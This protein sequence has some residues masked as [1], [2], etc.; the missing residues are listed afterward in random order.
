MPEPKKTNKKTRKD[1]KKKRKF[2]G[3]QHTGILDGGNAQIDQSTKK[4]DMD[5]RKRKASS[6]TSP[7]ASLSKLGPPKKKVN[8]TTADTSAIE[9]NRIIDISLLVAFLEGFKCPECAEY[10]LSVDETMFG[11]ASKISI[12]CQNSDCDYTSSFETSRK[13]PAQGKGKCFAINRQFP[14]AMCA[15]G[16]HYS[17]LIRL[18]ANLDMP[19]PLSESSW[20]QHVQ[21]IA[22]FTKTVAQCSMKR[23]ANAVHK[24]GET[25]SDIT[26]SCDNTWQ[27]RGFS[28]KNGISTV[29]TVCGSTG[30]SR[31]LDVEVLSNFC[32]LCGIK[33]AK[34]SKEDFQKWLPSHQPNCSKNHDGTAGAMEPAGMVK[35]FKRSVDTRKLCYTGYLGDGD[36]KSYD[37]VATLNP[38]LYGKKKI[39]KLECCGHIQKRMGKRLMDKVTASKNVLYTDDKTGKKYKGLGGIGRLTQKTIQRIQGHYGAA[40]REN[41]GSVS[42]M[43]KAIWRIWKHYSDDHKDCKDWCPVKSGKG[44]SKNI[45]PKF[46]CTLIKPVFEALS[47]DELLQ[48]CM[49]G[50]SQNT[51]E[52]FHNLIWLRCPKTGF[53]GRTRLELAVNDATIVYNEGEVSRMTI[54]RALHL[55]ASSHLQKGLQNIDAKRLK[56]AY[57]PGLKSVIKSRRARSLAAKGQKTDAS[58][59]AGSF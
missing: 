52:S 19:S 8:T 23:A 53:V 35:I 49:H 18:A 3:N 16:R 25:I 12:V 24:D 45:L 33:R 39:E 34:L 46:V 47:S 9:G 4:D 50:G 36:S 15:I 41:H 38:P 56:N 17:H 48:K 43:K 22:D 5:K 54:F 32:S 44:Q 51:N 6:M 28:S 30:A 2:H 1:R 13:I 57:I 26:V 14:L 42:E 37:T 11:L 58:Y 20:R 21:K 55:N 7:N 29:L 10:N 31:V 27:R 40:I 59:A